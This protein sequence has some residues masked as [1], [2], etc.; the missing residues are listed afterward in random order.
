MATGMESMLG[1]L[2]KHFGVDKDEMI[3]SAREVHSAAMDVQR[4][5]VNIDVRLAAISARLDLDPVP[6]ETD[7]TATRM[8]TLERHPNGKS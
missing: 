2:F 1:M 4:R 5:L 8:I 3:N 6:V 7:G